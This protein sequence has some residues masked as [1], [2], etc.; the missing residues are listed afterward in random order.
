M[1]KYVVQ[2]FVKANFGRRYYYQSSDND[3]N[4]EIDVLKDQDLS[5][6]N[7]NN[8]RNNL[9]NSFDK[10]EIVYKCSNKKRKIKCYF[11]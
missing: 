1:R 9:I 5:I 8:A 7:Q 11:M 3:I 10:H 2:G 6:E 4:N